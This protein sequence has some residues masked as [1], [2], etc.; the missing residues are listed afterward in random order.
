M[1]LVRALALLAA[2]S[3]FRLGDLG[4]RVRRAGLDDLDE[5]ADLRATASPFAMSYRAA[6][7]REAN[8]DAA[9]ARRLLRETFCRGIASG[10]AACYVAEELGRPAIVGYCDVTTRAALGPAL[11]EHAYV[12]NLRVLREHRRRGVGERLVRACLGHAARAYGTL[13]SVALEVDDDND[14][15]ARLYARLGFASTASLGEPAALWKYGTFCWGRT[16]MYRP[17]DGR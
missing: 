4:L 11:G 17:N 1:R 10:A 14:A 12:K 9:E 16:L 15:A 7:N 5:L 3:G 13:D 6:A 8:D 2:A